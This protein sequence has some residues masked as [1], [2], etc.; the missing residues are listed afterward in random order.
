MGIE[1][2]RL[3][4]DWIS[5]AE[6]NKFSTVMNDILDKVHRLGPNRKLRDM[7]WER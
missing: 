7:R 6:A 2:D 5:A 3:K 4:V 1:K